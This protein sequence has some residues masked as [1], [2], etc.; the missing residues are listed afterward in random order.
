MKFICYGYSLLQGASHIGKSG[1]HIPFKKQPR[2]SQTATHRPLESFSSAEAL[3]YSI[4]HPFAP[5]GQRWCSTTIILPLGKIAVASQRGG[6]LKAP[7]G[8]GIPAQGRTLG[9]PRNEPVRSER[10]PHNPRKAWPSRGMQRPV[11]ALQMQPR[12]QPFF[13]FLPT[14]S[15]RL[16]F[17]AR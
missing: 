8:R 14:A 4:P 9:V 11:G 1:P 16:K 6:V 7:T 12:G 13:A 17:R 5:L 3:P 2:R 10:T 15:L